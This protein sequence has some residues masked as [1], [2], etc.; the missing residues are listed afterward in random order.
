MNL[1]IVPPYYSTLQFT[2]SEVEVLFITVSLSL[3]SFSMWSLYLLFY[4]SC[5]VSPQFFFRR[6]CSI[7]RC[8]F[9][10]SVEEVK[11]SYI[12]ILDQN[13]AVVYTLT[14]LA[15]PLTNGQEDSSQ[16]EDVFS[17]GA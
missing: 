12:A 9:G 10:V 13:Q 5:L 7:N 14:S 3:L 6:N 11:S 8:Q 16:K 1:L 4:R 2:V 15:Y 17:F